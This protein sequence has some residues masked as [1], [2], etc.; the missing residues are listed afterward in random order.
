MTTFNDEADSGNWVQ[1]CDVEEHLFSDNKLVVFL[2]HEISRVVRS[3]K[4]Q[5]EL[6]GSRALRT[7]SFLE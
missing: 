2:R 4:V 3:H 1:I 5:L 7:I 6:E